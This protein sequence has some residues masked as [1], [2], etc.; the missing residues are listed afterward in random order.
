MSQESEEW[1]GGSKES[2]CV[3]V[4]RAVAKG[5]TFILTIKIKG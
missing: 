2:F 4:R 1:G 5:K 3:H